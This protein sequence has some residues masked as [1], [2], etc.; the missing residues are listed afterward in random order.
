M[1]PFQTY[2]KNNSTKLLFVTGYPNNNELLVLPGDFQKYNLN[3]PDCL[4]WIKKKL[5]DSKFNLTKKCPF[6][7][8]GP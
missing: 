1:K 7:K 4:I 5:S 3:F 6:K 8:K 2:L